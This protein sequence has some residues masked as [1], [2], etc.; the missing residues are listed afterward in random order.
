MAHPNHVARL[1]ASFDSIKPRALIADVKALDILGEHLSLGISAEDPHW[2]PDRMPLL[3]PFAHRLKGKKMMLIDT[4]ETAKYSTSP[5][6]ISSYLRTKGKN[7]Q[8]IAVFA[9][10]QCV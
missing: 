9:K 4:S 1:E 7:S 5:K 10:A 8:Q 6:V 2:N 3:A